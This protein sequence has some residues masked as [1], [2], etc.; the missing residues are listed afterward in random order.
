MKCVPKWLWPT[1]RPTMPALAGS[2]DQG[3]KVA[4]PHHEA[5]LAQRR[6]SGQQREHLHKPWFVF[7]G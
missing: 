3:R 6:L 1:L 2:D 4:E 7:L 5:A